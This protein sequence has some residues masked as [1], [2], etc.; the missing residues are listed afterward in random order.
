MKSRWKVAVIIILTL[1]GGIFIWSYCSERQIE[2]QH[3]ADLSRFDHEIAD[4]RQN[5]P[6]G[7]NRVVLR[8]YAAQ[9]HLQ[10]ADGREQAYIFFEHISS[11]VWYCSFWNAQA[12]ISFSKDSPEAVVET[13]TP[14]TPGECM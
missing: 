2:R 11:N 13:I 4:L 7:A 12:R 8:E 10:F 9:H 5:V 14:E 3:S 6:I 1:A